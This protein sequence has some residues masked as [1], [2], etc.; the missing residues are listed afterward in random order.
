VQTENPSGVREM[1]ERRYLG[2]RPSGRRGSARAGRR[3]RG[4]GSGLGKVSREG[5][6]MKRRRRGSLR[7][8]PGEGA[9]LRRRVAGRGSG[10]DAVG[11][12]APP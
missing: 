6:E 9:G 1:G 4:G 2:P 12:G 5:L 7:Q 11:G 3:G 10:G 8:G